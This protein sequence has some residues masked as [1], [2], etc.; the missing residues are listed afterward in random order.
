MP[1]FIVLH[2]LSNLK[3]MPVYLYTTLLVFYSGEYEFVKLKFVSGSHLNVSTVRQ[4]K[5]EVYLILYTAII[6]MLQS[7]VELTKKSSP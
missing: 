1:S 2:S 7:K 6:A 5:G 4:L 3:K